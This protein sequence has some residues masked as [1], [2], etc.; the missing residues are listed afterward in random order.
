M[1]S[2]RIASPTDTSETGA[3]AISTHFRLR[4]D[5]SGRQVGRLTV[6]K[7]VSRKGMHVLY[8][9]LCSCGTYTR[10]LGTHLINNRTSSC[11]CL[12]R[13]LART[14]TVTHGA[15]RAHRPTPTYISWQ[16]M[17]ARVND[18]NRANY[19]YYGGRG[20][21][22]CERWQGPNGFQNFLADMGERPEGLSLDRRNNDG[23]YEPDNCRWA[24][25]SQQMKNRRS[26]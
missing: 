12:R 3:K 18:P 20:I 7:P 2:T 13:E 19:K 24:T 9:C 5:L 11:G 23:N 26:H 8:D 22:I 16:G 10:V 15:T 25:R 21:S 17:N 4:K 14:K 6:I 1:Q